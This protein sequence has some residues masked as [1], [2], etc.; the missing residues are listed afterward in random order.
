MY[1]RIDTNKSVDSE[2][3]IT[4]NPLEDPADNIPNFILESVEQ[5]LSSGLLARSIMEHE[6]INT[7]KRIKNNQNDTV[8]ED[9][10]PECQYLMPTALYNTNIGEFYRI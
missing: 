8:Q 1:Q 4:L 6:I 2:D 3:P 7:G 9:T 10:L 5:Y